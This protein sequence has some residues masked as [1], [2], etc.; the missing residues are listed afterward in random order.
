VLYIL[1]DTGFTELHRS[2]SGNDIFQSAFDRLS[3]N[4]FKLPVLVKSCKYLAV[5][6]FSGF[7]S[8]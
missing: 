4:P 2:I 8:P 6:R 1:P 5:G 3:Q 7:F